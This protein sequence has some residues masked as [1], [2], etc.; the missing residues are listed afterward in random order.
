MSTSTQTRILHQI[1]A[2]DHFC[3]VRGLFKRM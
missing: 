1:A 2:R 3:I